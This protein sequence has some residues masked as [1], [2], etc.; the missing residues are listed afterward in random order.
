MFRKKVFPVK[1]KRGFSLRKTLGLI[2]LILFLTSGVVIA[3]ASNGVRLFINGREVHP[4]VPPQIVNDRTMVPL[5]FVAETFGAEVGWDN[6]T[7]SVDIKY[8][9]GGQADAGELNEYLAWLIKAKSEFEELSSINFSKP[10]TYQATVD[11]RKH[12]TK[13]G[14]LI[15]DAQNICPPK[16][17]CED[18][19]KLLV[20][21]TQF[22]ISLDLVIRASEEYR[23]GNYMAALAVLEAVVDIIPR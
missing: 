11:I 8:A 16:E 5:R 15:S 17:Q 7:R 1:N 20:M 2:L 3:N 10:F 22:K 13:V 21:M 9:G 23:A 6:S 12:S 19:H 18:F 14:S 4:D